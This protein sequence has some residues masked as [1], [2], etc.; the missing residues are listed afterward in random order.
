MLFRSPLSV[1]LS[2]GASYAI[3]LT[4][5]GYEVAN[6]AIDVDDSKDRSLTIEL[7]PRIGIVTI[8]SDPPDAEL[9]VDGRRRG[10]ASQELRLTATAH[11]IEIR[12]NGFEPFVIE[13]TPKPGFPQYL[14]V[15]LLTPEEAVL[16]S[17]VPV[18]TTSQV[19]SMRLSSRSS[20]P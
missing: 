4:K 14:E 18:I 5:A 3:R 11:R 12:K 20:L 19:M 1:E 16:A 13:V 8:V 10:N 6:R 7:R 15:N 17:M 9:I 2:K